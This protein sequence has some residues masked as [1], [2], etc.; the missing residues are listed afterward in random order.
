MLPFILSYDNEINVIIRDGIREFTQSYQFTVYLKHLCYVKISGHG[1]CFP[2][3]QADTEEL[4]SF[5]RVA[6]F[7]PKS[8]NPHFIFIPK[9][10]G[11]SI[12]ER[13]SSSLFSQPCGIQGHDGCTYI[14]DIRTLSIR[15]PLHLTICTVFLTIKQVS[16]NQTKSALTRSLCSDNYY[17]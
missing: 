3:F 13:F 17:I 10:I 16:Q 12:R 7:Q 5:T 15:I 11:R 2:M 6:R 4:I 14:S 9:N 8:Q 1:V